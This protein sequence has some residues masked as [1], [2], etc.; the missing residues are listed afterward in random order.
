M[1]L[2][3]WAEI[4]RLRNFTLKLWVRSLKIHWTTTDGANLK[5]LT[6][7]P[8]KCYRRS[9]LFKKGWSRRPKTVLKRMWW[10][11]RKKSCMLSWRIFYLV[12]LVQKWLSNWAST[13]KIWR[14]RPARWSQWPLSLICTTRRSTITSTR[15]KDWQESCKRWNDDTMSKSAESRCKERPRLR[16][17]VPR[18]TESRVQQDP[19]SASQVEATTWL[20]EK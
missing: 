17:V 18:S 19:S 1:K 16:Q 6:Q 7:T 15:S 13:S 11:K 20:F 4:F 14:R 2:L 3:G 10:S 12:S 9:K 5:E 8:G